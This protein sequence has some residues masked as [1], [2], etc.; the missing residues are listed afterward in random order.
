MGRAY[1][2][3]LRALDVGKI[4]V[5]SR[6][7][8]DLADLRDIPNVETAPGGIERLT[9]VPGPDELV[10]VAT[11]TDTLVSFSKQLIGLGFRRLLIE[12]P[13][14]LWASE[15]EELAGFVSARGTL[16]KCAYNRVAYPS[17]IEVLKRCHE[18]G[19][20]TS[21]AYDFT[22]L[23]RDDWTERF[24]VEE[25]KHW[26]LANSVHV[27]SMAH[28]IGGLPDHWNSYRAG[29][30][31]WHPTGSVFVGSGMTRKGVPFS[32][33]A[34]WDSKAR[35]SVEVHTTQSTYRLCPLEQAFRKTSGLGPYEDVPV[36]VFAPDVKAGLAEQVAGM[37][38]DKIAAM[39]PMFSL[40]DAA[41]LT[42]YGED[43]FGYPAGMH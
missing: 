42:R 41:V 39:M 35:W 9:R 6:S 10:I 37:L 21:V 31:D 33:H 17:V 5:C 28:G 19:G 27:L 34:D 43:V 3:A 7:K 30:L 11:P 38:D 8:E 25:L 16:A 1:L 18:E 20:I 26:G 36:E 24:A 4:Y 13:V 32:Y 29:G 14:S 12:K 15:I 23:I 40:E 22:E 2:D